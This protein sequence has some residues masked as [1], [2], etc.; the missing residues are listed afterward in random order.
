MAAF[1][2][3]DATHP[4]GGRVRVSQ[5]ADVFSFGALVA[6]L[7]GACVRPCSFP[8]SVS[9]KLCMRRDVACTQ[10]AVPMGASCVAPR[11]PNCLSWGCWRCA[12]R[13]LVAS[14]FVS[15]TQYMCAQ[16]DPLVTP[17]SP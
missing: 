8:E 2:A 11:Y 15:C 5:Q 3:V 10:S 14:P 1:S 4:E 7:Y 17:A 6:V 9:R 12:S 16:G 13:V